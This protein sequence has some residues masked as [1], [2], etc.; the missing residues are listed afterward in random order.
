MAPLKLA[1]GD[2]LANKRLPAFHDQLIVAPLKP[3]RPFPPAADSAAFHDQL[4][5][6]P[7]KHLPPLPPAGKQAAFHDQ[8]IVAPLKP[9]RLPDFPGYFGTSTIN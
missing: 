6:A 2:N 4:I 7:L 3:P 1:N 8:L 9:V 5:V